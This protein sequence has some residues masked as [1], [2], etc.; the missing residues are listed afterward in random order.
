MQ[1]NGHEIKPST[2]IC[3]IT[4]VSV[5]FFLDFCWH[6]GLEHFINC[7]RK[8]DNLTILIIYKVF[9]TTHL[10]VFKTQEI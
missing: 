4:F 8:E 1:A 7:D 9:D 5:A 2:R 3:I 10:A 6:N